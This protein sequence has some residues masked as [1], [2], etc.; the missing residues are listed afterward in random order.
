MTDLLEQVKETLHNMDTGQILT[1]LRGRNDLERL[2][3]DMA[4]ALIAQDERLKAAD[5]LAAQCECA[6]DGV[7]A[8]GS[9]EFYQALATYRALKRSG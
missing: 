5:V 3:F 9:Q 8:T 4:R 1:R 6:F 2:T 7:D